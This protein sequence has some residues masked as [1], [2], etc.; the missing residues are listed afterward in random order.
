ML[1]YILV[2]GCFLTIAFSPFAL[3]KKIQTKKWY[4]MA[5]KETAPFHAKKWYA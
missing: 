5:E 4:A 3:E 2:L 1:K